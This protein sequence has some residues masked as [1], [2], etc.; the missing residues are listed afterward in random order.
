MRKA[1]NDINRCVACGVCCKECPRQ[2]IEIYKGCY[3]MVD[4][5]ICVGCGICEK[6]CPA[7][8]ITVCDTEEGR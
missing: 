8:S 2:A 6:A 7:G 4:T 1:V 3:A 5:G